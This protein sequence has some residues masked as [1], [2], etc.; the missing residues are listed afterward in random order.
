MTERLPEPPPPAT[1]HPAR[2]PEREA[3]RRNTVFGLGLFGLFLLLLGGSFV[4][5]LVY[6][7]LD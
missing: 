3:V 4:V 2:D 7:A 5:A 6:L 1:T